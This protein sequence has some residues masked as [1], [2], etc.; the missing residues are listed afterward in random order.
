M[1]G[2]CGF[3]CLEFIKIGIQIT[4]HCPDRNQ[5]VLPEQSERAFDIICFTER[6]NS[7]LGHQK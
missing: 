2:N 5:S 4:Q 1:L 7:S 3:W 6:E